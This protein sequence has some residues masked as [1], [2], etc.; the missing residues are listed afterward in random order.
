MKGGFLCHA[1]GA[2]AQD[3]DILF[4]QRTGQDAA[5]GDV[6]DLHGIIHQQ[7]DGD[8]VC[9]VQR[10]TDHAAANGI[11]VETDQQVEQRCPV[12]DHDILFALPGAE[13]FLRKIKGII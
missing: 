9:T 3:F 6:A 12:P 8:D 7:G 2:A 13:N 4:G 1:A 11:A 5:V 10:L